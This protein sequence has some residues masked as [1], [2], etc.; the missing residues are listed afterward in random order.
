MVPLIIIIIII[1]IYQRVTLK[2]RLKRI[3]PLE[4]QGLT[5]I[6]TG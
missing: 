6:Q 2:H 1:I 3:E 4:F 5:E